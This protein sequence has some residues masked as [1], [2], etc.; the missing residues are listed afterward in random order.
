VIDYRDDDDTYV[1]VVSSSRTCQ[2]REASEAL[3]QLQPLMHELREWRDEY[4]TQQEGEHTKHEV[5]LEEVRRSLGDEMAK[6]QAA[7]AEAE[8]LLESMPDAAALDS[9]VDKEALA[10]AVD[11]VTLLLRGQLDKSH[12]LTKA[13]IVEL[14][15]RLAGI[16]SA[17]DSS[18]TME[19]LKE[20][21]FLMDSKIG[22]KA[23]IDELAALRAAVKKLANLR[24]TAS[25]GSLTAKSISMCLACNRPIYQSTETPK[26]SA[27]NS[28]MGHA[29]TSMMAERHRQTG[30]YKM[31]TSA[32]AFVDL[33]ERDSQAYSS[34][35]PSSRSGGG[36][37][38]GSSRASSRGGSREQLRSPAVNLSSASAT[39]SAAGSD[40]FLPSLPPR[41]IS[42][43]GSRSVTP[44]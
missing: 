9:F 29:G 42:R 14:E 35:R 22:A 39:G 13:E 30:V 2:A 44:M 7:F 6:M 24:S 12:E 17:G 28:R 27:N 31:D 32:S 25:S 3:Q 21:L 10:A 36:G 20:S 33:V 34:E 15:A 38:G 18:E 43:V 19:A 41:S 16:S 23:N 11:D 1:M 4:V 26:S 5:A 40:F 37:G 8:A